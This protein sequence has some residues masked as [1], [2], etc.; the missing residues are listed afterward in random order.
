MKFHGGPLDG[1]DLSKYMH[2]GEKLS[3]LDDD[4]EEHIYE[5][6]DGAMHYS[7][8]CVAREVAKARQQFANRGNKLR[9]P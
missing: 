5:R 1:D 3:F 9:D 6:R 2:D 8:A 7:D 4:G